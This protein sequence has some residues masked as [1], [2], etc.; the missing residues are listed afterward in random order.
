L[1][2]SENEKELCRRYYEDI[3]ILSD[4]LKSKFALLERQ[5]LALT[6]DFHAT[7]CSDESDEVLLTP[8][9]QKPTKEQSYTYEPRSH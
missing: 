5:L 1:G 3:V 9:V 2:V 8:A 4:Q 7:L 6:E